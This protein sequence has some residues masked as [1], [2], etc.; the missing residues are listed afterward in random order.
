MPTSAREEPPCRDSPS[1]RGHSGRLGLRKPAALQRRIQKILQNEPFRDAPQRGHEALE[2]RRGNCLA[3]LPSAVPLGRD[4]ALLRRARDSGRGNRARRR[5]YARGALCWR[6]RGRGGRMRMVRSLA[7]SGEERA[8]RDALRNS[9]PRP[10]A[11]AFAGAR[12]VRP[13]L[14]AVGNICGALSDE[15][16][17]ARAVPPRYARAGVLRRL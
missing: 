14:R 16:N 1:R 6:R 13:V 12:D 17:K 10:S 8:R 2:R 4:S 5:V 11:P 9:A 7:Q 15:R 3:R